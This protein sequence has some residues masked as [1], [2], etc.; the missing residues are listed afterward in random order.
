MA[1]IF[2]RFYV[3]IAAVVIFISWVISNNFVRAL[4]RDTQTMDAV[5]SEQAQAQQF[6]NLS[7]GQRDLLRKM[8][9]IQDSLNQRNEGKPAGAEEQN[10]EDEVDAKQEWVESFASDCAQLTESAEELGE[11]AKRV[12]PSEELEQ[13]VKSIIERT[14]AFY[15][16]LQREADA[17]TQ[18]RNTGRPSESG[19][20]ETDAEGRKK[21][22]EQVSAAFE[23]VAK[24][25]QTY[26]D[27]NKQVVSLY[28]KMHT[29]ITETRQ[30]SAKSAAVASFIALVFYAFGTVIGGLGKWLENRRQG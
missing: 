6:S 8:A 3:Y 7:D 19:P 21:Q 1:T 10:D 12:R 17:Y 18:E 13:S 11:L 29:Q 28:D 14:K 22:D 26:D 27:L 9:E 24:M 23:K 20:D 5:R 25:E 16:G 15:D 30:R 4:E 2:S